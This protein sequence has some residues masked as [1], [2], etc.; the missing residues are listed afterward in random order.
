MV[1]APGDLLAIVLITL[2]LLTPAALWLSTSAPI[3]ASDAPEP[4]STPA[5]R[6]IVTAETLS[7]PPP[8]PT[9][10]PQ[11][12]RYAMASEAPTKVASGDLNGDGRADLAALVENG[13]SVEVFYQTPEGTFPGAPSR[14][15][16][17]G[18]VVYSVAIGDLS[19]DGTDD[20][21]IGRAKNGS[22]S[23]DQV[24]IYAGELDLSKWLE[25]SMNDGNVPAEI[26]VA[27][28]DGDAGGQH[29][30][31][32]RLQPTITTSI[33]QTV[34]FPVAVLDFKS[35]VLSGFASAF[36]VGNLTG[37]ALPE[38]AVA[39]P[40]LNRVEVF[41]PPY[42]V[43]GKTAISGA[44][45]PEGPIDLAVD[46][47][48]AHAGLRLIVLNAR[49]PSIGFH[50]ADPIIGPRNLTLLLGDQPTALLLGRFTPDGRQDLAILSLNSSA[51]IEYDQLSQSPWFPSTPSQ[52][53]PLPESPV[54]FSLGPSSGAGLAA[55][56]LVA[57]CS[58][59]GPSPALL[60]DP[61]PLGRLAIASAISSLPPTAPI[62]AAAGNF[63][64]L[65]Q[66]LA[67]WTST[68]RD[69]FVVR[70]P[71]LPS[72]VG[73][74][75]T[76][77]P[78]QVAV[79]DLDR[80]GKADVVAVTSG[81]VLQAF[82]GSATFS[83]E[84]PN[85]TLAT[86]WSVNG[87]V[88][89]DL[90]L[91]G[92]ADLVVATTNG[93][94]LFAGHS[95][96]FAQGSTTAN[97][98]L[99]ASMSYSKP[100]IGDFNRDGR[101]DLAV[102][103]DGGT[104]AIELYFLGPGSPWTSWPSSAN[105]TLGPLPKVGY[106]LIGDFDGELG[107]DLLSIAPDS[108]TASEWLNHGLA[109]FFAPPPFS[110]S[111][112]L[113]SGL[114]V[115][116]DL[117]D[118]GITDLLYA[119]P[120]NDR[121]VLRFGQRSI[122]LLA[123]ENLS[124]PT[125]AN[126]PVAVLSDFSA[127]AK[128][129]FVVVGS[130]AAAF[131]YQANRA[132]RASIDPVPVTLEGVPVSISSSAVDGLSDL[133]ALEYSW[134]FGDGTSSELSPSPTIAHAYPKNRTYQLNLTVRDRE[135]A[136]NWTSAP[137]TITDTGPG[138]DFEVV[139]E[140]LEEGRELGFRSL[141]V[142][143]DGIAN[144]TWEF[145]DGTKAYGP[146]VSHTYA[147]ERTYTVNLSAKDGDGTPGYRS[148]F[149]AIDGRFVVVLSGP[150]AAP[151]GANISIVA[152]V[153][154]HSL[155][156]P[157]WGY[158]W[159]ADYNGTFEADRTRPS[160]LLT[161]T[162]NFT[163][164][165]DG[166]QRIAVRAIDSDGPSV[167]AVLTITV[168]DTVPSL[169]I[170]V[171]PTILEG[172]P[173]SI[174]AQI[175]AFDPIT[176]L[177][178]R[179]DGGPLLD[180]LVSWTFDSN[181]TY[182]ISLIASDAD[183]L[184]PTSV[185]IQVQV[186]DRAP[187]LALTASGPLVLQ[188]FEPLN[189]TV[190]ND[191][192]DPL[193]WVEVRFVSG[194]YSESVVWTDPLGAPAVSFSHGIAQPGDYSITVTARDFDGAQTGSTSLLGRSVV[195]ILPV[196]A[197]TVERLDPSDPAHLTFNA[198]A[199]LTLS[200]DI[201]NF[202]WS[203]GDGTPQA[204]GPVVEHTYVP[205]RNYTVTLWVRDDDPATASTTREFYLIPPRLD[206]TGAARL[207]F[208]NR[209]S[210]VSV[211]VSD[212]RGLALVTYSF[213]G[214]PQG[215]L[216]AFGFISTGEWLPGVHTLEVRAVDIDGNWAILGPLSLVLDASA[217]QLSLSEEGQPRP[218]RGEIATITVEVTD[219]SPV[220][221]TL[222]YRQGEEGEFAPI[223]IKVNPA[224]NATNVT[225]TIPPLSTRA[226]LSYYIEA[227][228]AAGNRAQT[229]IFTASVGINLWRE[230]GPLALI[231]SVAAGVGAAS[232]W[233]FALI[234]LVEEVFL[235]SLDGRLIAHTT[236]RLRPE[237]DADILGGM[238]V[239]IQ[240]FVKDSFR[241]E[242]LYALKQLDFGEHKVLIERGESVFLAVV[243]HG[244]A[245]PALRTRMQHVVGAV[246]ARFGT[247]LRRWDGDFERVRGIGELTQG[248]YTRRRPGPK[249]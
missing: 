169:E 67:I 55:V 63:T 222:W 61:A 173:V 203:F 144:L 92:D 183:D 158:E 109:P 227:E 18:V 215:P 75:A 131:W 219:A 241:D 138:V 159:D 85:V 112:G 177:R 235:I 171:P 3:P 193:V 202:T 160:A 189:L 149:V 226:A 7:V 206:L 225:F 221:L 168:E 230:W 86:D 243:V 174:S 13:N 58:P 108:V 43:G 40:S 165:P 62:G 234:T 60:L 137:V 154:D 208:V 87:L 187:E 28:L 2:T 8:S 115:A 209:T 12:V 11:F 49:I 249:V 71:G 162:E 104:D 134:E 147:Q 36:A 246:E 10:W 90:D 196:A 99:F 103:K 218:E 105:L 39:Y 83:P 229:A 27:D 42:S 141:A 53:L 180:S 33:L 153:L 161:D 110:R 65:G 74:R 190:E 136:T 184:V 142:A 194:Q 217:P 97:L 123:G 29:D 41:G 120:S 106:L 228:D 207:G 79:G 236:R 14:T 186:E 127:D 38:I 19:N 91:D 175:Q 232:W 245:S 6:S 16:S 148:R 244:R 185:T 114:P 32:I 88:M 200:P 181:G 139:A 212:D 211:Q 157:F 130:G 216:P 164:G 172:I 239:T 121:V 9:N 178:W 195:G 151:E 248:L 143:H 4:Q 35:T 30:L 59:C 170:V 64:G 20:L 150:S 213:D 128:G 210:G 205:G 132:P 31:V 145:G 57:G 78:Q 179:I 111:F 77:P 45:I 182:N 201:Q 102:V 223:S 166:L 82:R 46:S 69:I 199:S 70:E 140:Q 238:F 214:V 240:E 80:D 93:L 51:L 47:S 52:R 96:F 163:L 176:E 22:E 66:S 89:G 124:L 48:P 1:R 188:E 100:R 231:A 233:R 126:Y 133:P 247:V 81:S 95:G 156:D 76:T 17:P 152:T 242:E 192:P 116:A 34:L 44:S 56:A 21:V 204:Y 50:P 113:Y 73:W 220:L 125:P 23:K 94:R 135:G 24:I 72:E 26:I 117:S 237:R 84:P 119:Q 101:P 118:D 25:L 68:L 107:L 224:G 5:P 37:S 197:F 198:S 146:L 98:S 167:P 54:A 191:A 155:I 15:L 129:D 122:G